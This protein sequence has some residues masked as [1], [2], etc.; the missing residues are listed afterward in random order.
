MRDKWAWLAYRLANW[1]MVHGVVKNLQARNR[2][3]VFLPTPNSAPPN[4]KIMS[5]PLTC[6][7]HHNCHVQVK[8][9]HTQSVCILPNPIM[10]QFFFFFLIA[11]FHVYVHVHS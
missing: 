5:T 10:I 3:H 7:I 1:Y 11:N 9:T 2:A 4:S 6:I 8:N